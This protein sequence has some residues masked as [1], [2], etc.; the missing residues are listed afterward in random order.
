MRKWNR[1]DQ[2]Q[3]AENNQGHA[4]PMDQ[5]V[6]WILVAFGILVEK[7]IYL[8]F[9]FHFSCGLFLDL[10]HAVKIKKAADKLPLSMFKFSKIN[11]VCIACVAVILPNNADFLFSK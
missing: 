3:Q 8:P 4:D 7:H 10:G 2:C 9:W 5:F 1:P 11:L 6:C